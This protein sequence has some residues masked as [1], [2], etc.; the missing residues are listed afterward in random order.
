MST[1]I[2]VS[3]YN[4]KF[5]KNS[6]GEFSFMIK[7]GEITALLG[8]SGS[9]KSVLINSIVSCY[10]KFSG[11]IKINEKS[12]KKAGGFKQNMLVGFY[13]QI[14]FSLQSFSLIQFLLN[15]S[16][17]MGLKKKDAKE[18]IN[19]WID[20]FELTDSA[21]KK[22]KNFSWGMKNRV[23]LILGFLKE[24]EILILDEPGANLDSY[25]RNKIKNLLIQY[26]S[27]GKTII[28]TSHNI[29]EISEIIDNYLVIENGKLL[30]EGTTKQLN[31][32]T[33]YKIYVKEEYEVENFREFLNQRNIKSFKYDNIE[34]SLTIAIANYKELNYIFLYLIKN[35]LPMKNLVKLP[36]NMESIHKALEDSAA[37]EKNN[38]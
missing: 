28:I 2:E 9:G 18:R 23:N 16:M 13:T 8:V 36:T 1:I 31:I 19:Y 17:I 30:F 14:D 29:D 38:K 32:Y 27:Q 22:V 5:K 33:K 10:K 4:K 21:T 6:V 11:N 7:K 34:N 37:K 12:I 20:F 35:N 3:K 24:P 25:W 26:K 15:M